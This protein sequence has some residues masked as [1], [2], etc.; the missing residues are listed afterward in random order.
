MPDRRLAQELPPGDIDPALLGEAA[1]WLVRFQSGDDS[2]RTR[3]AFERWRAQSPAH[4]AAWRRAETVLDTFRRVPA[5]VG[6]RTLGGLARPGR[7]RAL[8]A[9]G[10]ATVA[11]PAA[12]LAWRHQPWVAWRAD[13]ATATGEQRRLTLDDGTQ[14]VL[15]T[16]TAVN[17]AFTAGER[18]L[19]L[20]R[21]EILVT[22]AEDPAPQPRPFVVETAEGRLRPLGTRFSVRQGAYESRVA[23]LEG[24]VEIVTTG[25]ARRTLAAGEQA[26]FG[27]DRI[28]DAK[29]AD[30]SAALW[31]QGMLVARDMPLAA[32][33]AELGRYRPGVLRC[34]PAV[35]DL[36]VS[37]AFPLTDVDAS[38]DLLVRT[39]PLALRRLTRYWVSVEPRAQSA[40]RMP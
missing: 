5:D 10:L 28:G 29:P 9:L 8:H 26:G 15:D 30:A 4:A 21:G 6:R 17:V 13:L 18:R 39:R 38:L 25:G 24:A 14:L 3:R 34:H 12:W 22:T 1:D 40:T 16:G 23:V 11:T 33:L 37:G 36:R 27:T 31:A 32:L 19:R 35:A 20:I 7:R 2:V